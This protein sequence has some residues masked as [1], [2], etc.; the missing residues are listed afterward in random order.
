M[1]WTGAESKGVRAEGPRSAADLQRLG[2]E[3]GPALVDL[4]PGHADVVRGLD[5]DAHLI[6]LQR[7]DGDLNVAVDDG[8]LAG[9]AGENQHDRPSLGGPTDLPTSMTGNP[10]ASRSGSRGGQPVS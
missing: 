6:A 7:H 1:T 9:V 5:A 10:R 4:L 3:L 2:G 8:L